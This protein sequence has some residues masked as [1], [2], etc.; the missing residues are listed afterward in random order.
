MVEEPIGRKEAAELEW[1]GPELFAEQSLDRKLGVR[2][3]F[4]L[5]GKAVVASETQQI[6]EI[7]RFPAHDHHRGQLGGLD[8]S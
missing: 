8:P 2:P 7:A 5:V 6:D 4:R 1:V 3:Q